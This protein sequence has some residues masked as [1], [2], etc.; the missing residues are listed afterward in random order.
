MI[1]KIFFLAFILSA[2]ACNQKPSSQSPK[3]IAPKVV[4]AH[5][6]V[7]PQDSMGKPQVVVVNERTLKKIPAGKPTV[8]LTNTNIHIAITTNIHLAETPRVC[9]PGTDTFLLPK[10]VPARDSAF[11]AG[12][13]EVTLA[14]VTME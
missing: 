12:I 5:G 2:I 10:K 7:V 3:T 9:T 1:K 4:E 14:K 6:Y 8:V 11:V 13:P